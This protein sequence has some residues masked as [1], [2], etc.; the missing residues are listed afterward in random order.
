MKSNKYLY[1]KANTEKIKKNLENYKGN[2]E[3]IILII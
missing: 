1:L 3:L 2:E